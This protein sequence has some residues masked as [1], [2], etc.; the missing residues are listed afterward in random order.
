MTW[1]LDFQKTANP[2]QFGG[3]AIQILKFVVLMDAAYC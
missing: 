1:C 3:H 2:I